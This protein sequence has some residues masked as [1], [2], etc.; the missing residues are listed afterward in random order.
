MQLAQGTKTVPSKMTIPTAQG[1]F[2]RSTRERMGLTQTDFSQRFSLDPIQLMD[3]ER[4]L[5]NPDPAILAYIRVIAAYPEHVEVA[6]E[7]VAP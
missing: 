4:N 2:I 6:L 1:D 7:Y 5:S 3:W